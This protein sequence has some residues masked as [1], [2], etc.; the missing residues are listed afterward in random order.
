MVV[1]DA[2]FFITALAGPLTAHDQAGMATAKSFFAMVDA[3]QETFTTSD[4][5]I[6]EVVFILHSVRH[7]NLQHGGVASH[8]KPLLDMPGCRV[9]AKRRLQRALDRWA[10]TSALSCVDALAVELALDHGGALGTFDR[11]LGQ[12]PGVT[13]RRPPASPGST[14]S[15]N[16]T[17]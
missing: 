15:A 11:R 1:L 14:G 3:G 5:V 16:G 7:L 4:A 2:D 17:A 12:V 8:L 6:A 9:P 10:S 13:T